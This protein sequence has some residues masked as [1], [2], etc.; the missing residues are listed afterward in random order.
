MERRRGEWLAKPKVTYFTV[1]SDRGDGIA[2]P[3]NLHVSSTGGG[4][5]SI[6]WDPVEGAKRYGVYTI[7]ADEAYDSWRQSKALETEQTSVQLDGLDALRSAEAVGVTAVDGEGNESYIRA[8]TLRSLTG[9]PQD[10]PYTM[11]TWREVEDR[12]AEEADRAKNLAQ[13]TLVR[14]SM[15]RA[16]GRPG[17]IDSQPIGEN[18]VERYKPF[19]SMEYSR[20][21]AE[22]LLAMHTA[23]DVTEYADVLSASDYHD[24][25]REAILQNPYLQVMAGADWSGVAVSQVERDGRR[26]LQVC[27]GDH[28]A[29]AR[30]EFYAQVKQAADSITAGATREGALQIE[31]YLV[32]LTAYDDE[33]AAAAASGKSMADLAKDHPAAWA[34]GVLTVGKG[35]DTSYALSFDAIADQVGLTSVMVTEWAGDGPHAWNRVLLDGRWADIDPAWDDAGEQAT[36]TYQLK[37]ADTLDNHATELDWML[38]MNGSVYA[39]SVASAGDASGKANYATAADLYDG[40]ATDHKPAWHSWRMMSMPPTLAVQLIWIDYLAFIIYFL[41]AFAKGRGVRSH[42]PKQV[43][44]TRMWYTLGFGVVFSLAVFWYGDLGDTR[45]WI[46][47]AIVLLLPLLFVWFPGFI[48]AN[49]QLIAAVATRA[50]RR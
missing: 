4:A 27:Y 45:G 42:T 40:E 46:A 47:M 43:F 49:Q 5:V 29:Q 7:R 24:V 25:V 22:N 41:I 33:A 16:T 1:A 34:G 31:N 36:D 15:T 26:I 50:T 3:R 30:D 17:A 8:T 21:V 19:G 35:V 28:A 18:G 23:I 48:R 11:S 13:P 39:R 37:D 44:S 12:K 2:E 9:E 14:P 38:P 6:A 32:R 10:E 20:Y